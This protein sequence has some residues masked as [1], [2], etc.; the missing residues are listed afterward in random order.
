MRTQAM[1]RDVLPEW[2]RLEWAADRDRPRDG[3]ATYC[4]ACGTETTLQDSW[5]RD[6]CTD[7]DEVMRPM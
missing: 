7:H 5:T 1:P 4:N 2:L 3:N 6:L